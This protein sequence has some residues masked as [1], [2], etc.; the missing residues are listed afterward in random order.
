MKAPIHSTKHYVQM[1]LSNVITGS[2]VNTVLVAG[3][4]VADKNTV[5]EVEE[6]ALVKAV[7]IEL[8]LIGTTA[9]QFFTIVFGK[10]PSNAPAATITD[11][12]ALGDWDG[13]KNV[14]YTSQ[15]LA[16]NDGVGQPVNVIRQWFKI[17]KGKQRIG[18]NDRF[19]LQ[20]A[21][22]GDGQIDFCGFATYKEFT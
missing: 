10:Y 15:G 14:L 18:L 12:A 17:P 20:V 16:P 5:S 1:S 22:R 4:K 8:W 9:D 13:K 6:G 11:M 19:Q 3:V 21:S 2:V 7:Y